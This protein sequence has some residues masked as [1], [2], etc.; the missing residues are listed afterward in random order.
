[1]VKIKQVGVGRMASGKID[2]ITYVT[3]GDVTF[4][5]STPTAWASAGR[6]WHTTSHLIWA[7]TCQTSLSHSK[8]TTLQV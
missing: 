5:R 3:R 7:T 8:A 2:G 1:M 6:M 4:A